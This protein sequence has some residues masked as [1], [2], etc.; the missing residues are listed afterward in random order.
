LSF[1]DVRG[2]A[3][4]CFVSY[5]QNRQQYVQI[6]GTKSNFFTVKSGVPQ[7]SIRGP[8]LFLLFVNDMVTVSSTANLIMFVDDTNLFFSGNYID[9]S[10]KLVNLE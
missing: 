4:K 9:P 3:K 10:V 6:Q 8:L 7:G 1:Y 2:I 5:V